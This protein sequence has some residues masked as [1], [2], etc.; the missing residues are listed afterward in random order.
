[1]VAHLI[2]RRITVADKV[3]AYGLKEVGGKVVD[4]QVG[5]ISDHSTCGE[6]EVGREGTNEHGEYVLWLSSAWNT[7][8]EVAKQ[9]SRH[10]AVTFLQNRA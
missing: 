2:A 5:S 4:A 8:V 1:M 3:G 6:C 7:L 10:R 9:H